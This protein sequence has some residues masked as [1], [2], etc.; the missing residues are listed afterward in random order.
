MIPTNLR[1]VDQAWHNLSLN[2]GQYSTDQTVANQIAV[3]NACEELRRQLFDLCCALQAAKRWHIG[4]NLL[5]VM[6]TVSE[7]Q[8]RVATA[9][10]GLAAARN[11]PPSSKFHGVFSALMSLGDAISAFRTELPKLRKKCTEVCM[12]AA[13]SAPAAE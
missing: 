3:N 4:C 8:T 6:Q 11:A 7:Q 13:A 9:A 2:L 1:A 12:Q 5:P 10:T